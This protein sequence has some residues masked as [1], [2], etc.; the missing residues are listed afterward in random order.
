MLP[1]VS[2]SRAKKRRILDYIGKANRPICSII[3]TVK[4]SRQPIPVETMPALH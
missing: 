3:D 2:N 1:A 4:T